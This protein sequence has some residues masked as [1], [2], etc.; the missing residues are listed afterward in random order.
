MVGE[1][2]C[3]TPSVSE[4]RQ[5]GGVTTIKKRTT[6]RDAAKIADLCRFQGKERQPIDIFPPAHM[7]LIPDFS[8]LSQPILKPYVQAI[9][10]ST[11]SGKFCFFLHIQGL[12][13]VYKSPY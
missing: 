2:V 9:F 13:V 11:G 4:D 5:C 7:S 8:V 12:F 10:L 6:M 3:S 1:T